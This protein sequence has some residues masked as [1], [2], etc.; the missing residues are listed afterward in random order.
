MRY[1]YF[2]LRYGSAEKEFQR[3]EF[4]SKQFEKSDFVAN[5]F[6]LKTES[7]LRRWH[8]ETKE[9]PFEGMMFPVP[10]DY[11][12]LLTECYGDYMTPV[13]CASDH[14]LICFDTSRPYQEMIK[15]RD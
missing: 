10:I 9:I 1:L 6:Y 8:E 14:N 15:K 2:K 4:L 11:D 13:K 7:H 12:S 3:L 5:L